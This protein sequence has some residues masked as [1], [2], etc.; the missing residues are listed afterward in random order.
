MRIY[1]VIIRYIDKSGAYDYGLIVP[2][3]WGAAVLVIGGRAMGEGVRHHGWR[4]ITFSD[5][6]IAGSLS[7]I[8]L[9][10]IVF[11]LFVQT[12]PDWRVNTLFFPF[13]P[14]PLIR[15]VRFLFDVIICET[16]VQWKK[17]TLKLNSKTLFTPKDSSPI[18]SNFLW[19]T[20]SLSLTP[21]GVRRIEE[22]KK[23][24]DFQ[25]RGEKKILEG[26]NSINIHNPT[27]NSST[28]NI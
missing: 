20:P 23:S 17:K 18:S 16:R 15:I 28:P 5:W 3:L 4:M 12:T 26:S 14:P 6:D 13:A 24:E 27:S 10:Q 8:C 19:F 25:K 7:T 9:S 21:T 22:K 2:W 1:T 11:L